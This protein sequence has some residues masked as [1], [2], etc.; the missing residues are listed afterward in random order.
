MSLWRSAAA[1][2]ICAHLGPVAASTALV[3]GFLYWRV[4]GVID[5]EQRAVVETEIQGLAEDYDRAGLAGLRRA[6]ETR[7]ARPQ[8]RD[9]IYLLADARGQ[10]IAGNLSGWPPTVAP[11]TG[12]ALLELYRLDR[13][14]P[15]E[16]SALAVRLPNDMR[17][18]VGRDVAARAAFELYAGQGGG[19]GGGGDDPVVAG[20][21]LGAGA[22]DAAADRRHR[23]CGACDHGG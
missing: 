13:D 20:N 19:L 8:A 17:L 23:P 9:A 16:I 1:R 10:R 12:W 5:A 22:A 7:L 15:T 11:G 6:I 4:G 3:L 2:L 14:A 21:R 18:L